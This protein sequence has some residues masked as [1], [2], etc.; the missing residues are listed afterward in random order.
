MPKIIKKTS[1]SKPLS[2]SRSK[3]WYHNSLMG[4]AARI[5]I[6]ARMIASSETVTFNGRRLA[7]DIEAYAI[8]LRK[9]LKTRIDK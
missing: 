4:M 7:I 1:S 3:V 5:E 2:L 8:V 9:E 6:T